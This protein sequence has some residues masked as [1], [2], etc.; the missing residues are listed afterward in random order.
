MKYACAFL[1]SL[2]LLSASSSAL[3]NE[4]MMF[5][6]KPSTKPQHIYV[7]EVGPFAVPEVEFFDDAKR[8]HTM[9]EFQNEVVVLNFWATWCTSCIQKMPALDKLAKS[10]KR[11]PVRVV[12]L[13]QDFK[14]V[15]AV[16]SYFNYANIKHLDIYLDPRA[17]FF[18]ALN[19][20]S[21]PSTFIVSP[22]GNIVAR[23]SS[24]A[25][26]E[27]EGIREQILYYVPES[28]GS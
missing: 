15:Q 9:E 22:E 27:S 5:K 1:V 6:E 8:P 26:L 12:A 23:I 3:A 2:A 24:G 16:K 13:S 4:K 10:L 11:Y 21:I 17:N 19:L 18:R 14:G 7:Q 20:T 25:D 28:K